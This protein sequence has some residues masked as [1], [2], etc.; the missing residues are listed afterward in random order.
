[1]FFRTCKN[2]LAV[3]LTG[4]VVASFALA[5]PL[6]AQTRSGTVVEEIR[7]VGTQRID[8][9]TVNAYMQIKPGDAYDPAKVDDSL[10]NLFNTGLFA[11]V[12][13]RREGD[14]VVV[15]V[16]E[17]PIINRIAFE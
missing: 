8:P 6:S 9:S 15:Q 14:A 10:K 5:Q 7:V 3:V 4:G 11:D 12:T 16:V 17:N 2:V 13:L 1:M